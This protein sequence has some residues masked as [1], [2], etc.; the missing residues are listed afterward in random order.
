MNELWDIGRAEFQRAEWHQEEDTGYVVRTDK[1]LASQMFERFLE[2]RSTMQSVQEDVKQRCVLFGWCLKEMQETKL[3]QYVCRK[4]DG[5]GVNSN[6]GYTSFYK[7]CKDVFG[8]KD[9][10]AQRMVSIAKTFCGHSNYDEFN[11]VQ[12]VGVDFEFTNFSYSQL[13]ALL[14]VDEKYRM[15]IPATC[16][17][18][19]IEKL[20]QLYKSY[21]PSADTTYEDDLA[22]YKRRKDEEK[23]KK[24]AELNRL[25]F[26]P[27]Q[28]LPPVAVSKSSVSSSNFSDDQDEFDG[29][30]ERD[31]S[32]PDVPLGYT[33]PALKNGM[34]RQIELL[35]D[36][37]QTERNAGA[38]AKLCDVVKDALEY[39]HPEGVCSSEE[40]TELKC[41]LVSAK[42]APAQAK[43]VKGKK[44][45]VGGRLILKNAKER[46]EWLENY[47]SWG[48]WI[49]VPD[50]AKRFYRYNFA[51]GC[52][53]IIEQCMEYRRDW[54]SKDQATKEYTVL[55]YCIIDKDHP[56]YDSCYQ[57]GA[58]GIID[59][60]SKHSKEL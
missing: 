23:A 31:I 1:Q 14:Y 18:R 47:T 26:I 2:L 41:E 54:Y 25:T 38:W 21:V 19:N 55:K 56:R 9:R 33:L 15:R 5:F 57:G 32:T 51:N 11:Q 20:G 6:T 37:V 16:S 35:R 42:N 46:R 3:Y 24:T 10:T 30:D 45:S 58:S 34:L 4:T 44:T 49:D 40:L 48:V 17:K 29:E 59:W 8:I 28:K 53:L 12:H 39:D 13:G 50:V 43:K 52:S 36:T 22:E 7:F 27:A 60:L